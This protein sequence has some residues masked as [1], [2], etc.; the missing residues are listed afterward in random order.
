MRMASA[1]KFRPA[2]FAALALA[3]LTGTGLALAQ[4]AQI[5]L[6]LSANDGTGDSLRAAFGKVNTNFSL[7][8]QKAS[9]LSD[10]ANPVTART[11]LGLGSAATQSTGAFD[12]AGAPPAPPRQPACKRRATSPTS[13]AP[14]RP[15]RT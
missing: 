2:A 4:P 14:R 12:A 11:N 10:L 8:L 13:P 15:A 7:T 3:V 5:N 1:M 6:G 9:N